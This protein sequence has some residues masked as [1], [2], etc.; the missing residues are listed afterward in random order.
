MSFSGLLK[1]SVHRG[2]TKVLMWS[3]PSSLSWGK[4]GSVKTHFRT[5]HHTSAAPFSLHRWNHASVTVY[6][7]FYRG[8]AADWSLCFQLKLLC[9]SR[10]CEVYEWAHFSQWVSDMMLGAVTDVTHTQTETQSSFKQKVWAGNILTLLQVWNVYV[11]F[12]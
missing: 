12:F 10:M 2:Q 4:P 9:R 3:A 11:L 1:S 5:S 8:S 6:N 7:Q